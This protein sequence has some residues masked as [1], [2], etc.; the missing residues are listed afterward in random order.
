MKIKTKK[1]N[2]KKFFMHQTTALDTDLVARLM[3][4]IQ[5]ALVMDNVGSTG[6]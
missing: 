2:S 3:S 1:V 5:L 6:I 4:S